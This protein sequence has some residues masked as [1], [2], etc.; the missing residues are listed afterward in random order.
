MASGASRLELTLSQ[1]Q[2]DTLLEF[3]ALLLRWNRVYN[4]TAARS[5]EQVVIRHVLDSLSVHAWA[6]A[7]PALDVGSG[8][9]LPGL[10]LA[11][12]RP[13]LQF[14]LL[15]SNRKKARFCRQAVMELA[16][17]NV[18][19][20]C[21]RLARHRPPQT[22]ARILSRALGPVQDYLPDFRR[23]SAAHGQVLAMMGKRPDMAHAGVAPL[24]E[25]A[26]VLPLAVPG[27][28]A[29]RNLLLL[30]MACV[31]RHTA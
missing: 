1:S 19:V 31:E 5:A 25:C 17:E 12:A 14:V 2:L 16:L 22:Y 15:D 20:V 23:L 4:L 6:N 29:E 18:D 13:E 9:G 30:D 10:V 3:V 28:D 11:V 8:A 24:R 21:E 7:G 26:K 27:L